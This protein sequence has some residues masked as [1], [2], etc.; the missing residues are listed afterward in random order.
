VAT[1]GDG[2]SEQLRGL[3]R[4]NA[5]LKPGDSGGPLLN[6]SGRVIGVDTAASSGFVLQAASQGFAIPINRALTLARQIEA[7][8]MSATVHIGSTPFLGISVASDD[9]GQ[10]VAGALVANVVSGLPADQAGIVPGDTITALDGQ[11]VGSYQQLS[12][13]LLRHK[14]GDTITLTWVDQDGLE[15]SASV[16]TVAGPPQ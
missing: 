13:A 15:H 14:A 11:P 10:G 4:T 2:L 8:R 12:A 9:Q 6:A 7:G 1:D 3:I 16:T 5:P